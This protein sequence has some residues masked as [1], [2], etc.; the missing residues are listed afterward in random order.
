MHSTM[1]ISSFKIKREKINEENLTVASLWSWHLYQKCRCRQTRDGTTVAAANAQNAF[2]QVLN[3]NETE[4]ALGSWCHFRN[5][6]R[7]SH[8]PSK[9]TLIHWNCS[10]PMR[11][12]HIKHPQLQCIASV[13]STGLAVDRF[14]FLKCEKKQIFSAITGMLIEWC[15]SSWCHVRG[16]LVLGHLLSWRRFQKVGSIFSWKTKRTSRQYGTEQAMVY[17]PML[18][19]CFCFFFSWN[20][21]ALATQ[22]VVSI[23]IRL[24]WS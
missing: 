18:F 12:Q 19:I 17:F 2:A 10:C 1:P 9:H 11:A 6:I 5:S 15:G 24:F 22:R 8:F 16:P 20:S 3:R 21:I 13:T 14:H 4:I 23:D 7:I